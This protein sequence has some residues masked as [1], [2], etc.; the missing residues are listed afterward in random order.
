MWKVILRSDQVWCFFQ[1]R[2]KIAL[3]EGLF[4]SP[5]LLVSTEYWTQAVVTWDRIVPTCFLDSAP[6]FQDLLFVLCLHASQHAYT[7]KDCGCW[8]LPK[9]I[10][11]H[12]VMDPFNF[13]PSTSVRWQLFDL[14]W[15]SAEWNFLE[16]CKL[17]LVLC[18]WHF[19]EGENTVLMPIAVGF[20]FIL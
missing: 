20:Y 6:G 11:K 17:C 12:H 1:G 18:T 14:W 8:P 3:F 5:S 10:S 2:L 7:E 16:N 15:V 4:S 13:S 9:L 19:G